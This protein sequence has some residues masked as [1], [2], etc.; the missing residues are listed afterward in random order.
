MYYILVMFPQKAKHIVHHQF[1]NPLSS[2]VG[3]EQER[4]RCFEKS[5]FRYSLKKLGVY[6]T[7]DSDLCQNVSLSFSNNGR[8]LAKTIGCERTSVADPRAPQTSCMFLGVANEERLVSAVREYYDYCL[9]STTASTNIFTSSNKG[10]LTYLKIWDMRNTN[11]PIS[12]LCTNFGSVVTLKY[13]ASQGWLLF[14]HQEGKLCWWDTDIALRSCETANQSYNELFNISGLIEVDM[15][16]TESKLLVVQGNGHCLMLDNVDLMQL[17][18]Q[19]SKVQMSTN[20]VNG[21]YHHWVP[22]QDSRKYEVNQMA[23]ISPMNYLL[24]NHSTVAMVSAVKFFPLFDGGVCLIARVS[25]QPPKEDLPTNNFNLPQTSGCD[26]PISWNPLFT[27]PSFMPSN[28]KGNDISPG[29]SGVTCKK[30]TLTGPCIPSRN[31]SNCTVPGLLGSRLPKS[32]F[33]GPAIAGLHTAKPSP[34]STVTRPPISSTGTFGISGLPGARSQ[35]A[36]LTGPPI[37]SAGADHRMPQR[38]PCLGPRLGLPN[39]GAP[40][41]NRVNK[42]RGTP[43]AEEVVPG[44]YHPYDRRCSQTTPPLSNSAN[45]N[46]FTRFA[47]GQ[48]RQT[49]KDYTLQIVIDSSSTKFSP[50]G[51]GSIHE[52]SIRT[53]WYDTD[54]CYKPLSRKRMCVESQV[55][56]MP[57]SKGMKIYILPTTIDQMDKDF[58]FSTPKNL[59]CVTEVPIKMK[60]VLACSTPPTGEVLF[61]AL[62]ADGQCHYLKPQL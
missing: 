49:K 21:G 33:T 9:F 53:K 41:E 18:S 37:P 51:I 58:L 31:Q 23:S 14:G 50:M 43:G 42:H 29:N 27:G 46:P 6:R 57:S 7:V 48:C 3:N 19:F 38:T 30:P 52:N 32:T 56:V 13:A 28:S 47:K 24:K 12:T 61:A 36:T 16:P 20:I 4:S 39:F 35:N 2:F 11:K 59:E 8:F 40:V 62:D 45:R 15:D 44:R 1:S 22:N 34:K 60:S 5:L 17:N 25:V 54:D 10:G 55:M 26:S